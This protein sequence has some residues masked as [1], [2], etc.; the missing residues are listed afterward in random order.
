MS[1]IIHHPGTPHSVYNP[2]GVP[3]GVQPEAAG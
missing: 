3:V 2:A 1:V